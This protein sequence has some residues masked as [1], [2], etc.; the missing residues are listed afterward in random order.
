MTLKAKF[1]YLKKFSVEKYF[2]MEIHDF[3]FSREDM[4]KVEK[5]IVIRMEKLK[6]IY[7]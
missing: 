4:S 5:K 2:S 6:K 1:T 3:R 7:S